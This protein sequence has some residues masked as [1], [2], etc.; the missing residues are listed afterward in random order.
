MFIASPNLSS[1]HSPDADT[2]TEASSLQIPRYLCFSAVLSEKL[3][4]IGGD[5]GLNNL[6]DS[7][8]IG[9]FQ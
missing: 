8:E 9:V 5:M 7:I 4:V 2:W 1:S 3:Y 6:T